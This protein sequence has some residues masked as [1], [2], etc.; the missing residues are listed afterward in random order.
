MVVVAQAA[1]A[2]RKA[3]REPIVFLAP[4]PLQAAAV[5]V[6]L[7]PEASEIAAGLVV[8]VLSAHLVVLAHLVKVSLVVTAHQ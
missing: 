6:V 1:A 7:L 3:N 8:V 5:V 4:L 2:A